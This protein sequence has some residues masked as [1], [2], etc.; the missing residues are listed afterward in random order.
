MKNYQRHMLN[1]YKGIFLDIPPRSS[2]KTIRLMSKNIHYPGYCIAYLTLGYIIIGNILFFILVGLRVLFKHLF[3]VEEFA[4]VFIPILA[5]Y[6][7]KFII[8]W[9][10][11]KTFFLQK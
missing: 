3:L 6:F 10:L 5:F 4:K 7:M 1:A 9:F 2:F 8:Q 11:S